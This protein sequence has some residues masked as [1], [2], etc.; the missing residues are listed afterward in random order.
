MQNKYSTEVDIIKKFLC[1]KNFLLY[2]AW[3]HIFVSFTNSSD[4]N[5][6]RSLIFIMEYYKISTAA[7]G[8]NT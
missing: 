4:Y 1:E 3:F 6:K 7:A 5:S 2:K 8:G